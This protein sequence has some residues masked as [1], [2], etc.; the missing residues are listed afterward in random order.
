MDSHQIQWLMKLQNAI[1]YDNFVIEDIEIIEGDPISV[2]ISVMGDNETVLT[3]LRAWVVVQELKADRNNVTLTKNE[4][5]INFNGTITPER[6]KANFVDISIRLH[7]RGYGYN[8]TNLV[9]VYLEATVG[10]PIEIDSVS[11][12]SPL[13]ILLNPRITSDKEVIGSFIPSKK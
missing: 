10:K 13:R 3:D 5:N 2:S 11:N 9:E 8:E 6:I 7:Q 1:N 12:L 4:D